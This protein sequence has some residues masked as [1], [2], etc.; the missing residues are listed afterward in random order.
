MQDDG[1]GL[2]EPVTDNVLTRFP[3]W[4][5]IESQSMNSKFFPP[6]FKSSKEYQLATLLDNPLY[7]ITGVPLNDQNEW[8][9]RFIGLRTPMAP[10]QDDGIII[11]FKPRSS[12]ELV[13]QITN[14]KV[15]ISSPV[16]EFERIL[17]EYHLYKQSEVSLTYGLLQ[18]KQFLSK[19]FQTKENEKLYRTMPPMNSNISPSLNQADTPT[20]IVLMPMESRTFLVTLTRKDV[21]PHQ[22]NQNSMESFNQAKLEKQKTEA[23]EPVIP[24]IQVVD[25]KPSDPIQVI[26]VSHEQS[27]R[28]VN[29]PSLYYM[30]LST[31]IVL[32]F[33]FFVISKRTKYGRRFNSLLPVIN[34][35]SKSS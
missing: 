24:Q 26:V 34:D 25:S 11:S 12:S 18:E 17:H 6:V 27:S 9:R 13:M 31:M 19:R 15:D 14:Q 1:R 16:I 21:P 29:I 8:A 20:G 28:P 23:P 22:F 32:A 2:G 7:L 5:T 30:F 35:D 10:N 3:L 33:L 4:I